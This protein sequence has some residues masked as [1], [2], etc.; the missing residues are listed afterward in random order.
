ML[1]SK[2]CS[3]GLQELCLALIWTPD[4]L[5]W[6]DEFRFGCCLITFPAGSIYLVVTQ[7][8]PPTPLNSPLWWYRNTAT[9]PVI[10]IAL[11]STLSPSFGPGPGPSPQLY[12]IPSSYW[13][14][15]RVLSFAPHAAA[16]ACSS[17]T[18]RPPPA[19]AISTAEVGFVASF[20]AEDDWSKQ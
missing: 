7:A 19:S 15:L 1:R 12:Y 17:P 5:N 4:V 13:C 9:V 18:R 11:T 2:G 20:L 14:I 16:L 3:A 10:I 8:L 6:C